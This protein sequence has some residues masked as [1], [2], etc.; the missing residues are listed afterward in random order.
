MT[1]PNTG[2][3]RT[4]LVV[5]A[6]GAAA[7]G[8][9]AC[10]A[11]QTSQTANQVAAVDGGRG[12]AGELTVNNLQ[13]VLDDEGSEGRVGFAVSF[14]GYGVDEAVSIDSVQID[15]LPVQLGETQPMERGCSIIF[16]AHEGAEPGE[17]EG[18]ICVENAVATLPASEDLK[19]GTSVPATLTFSNGDQIETQA[20]I[21]G[22]IVEAGDFTR[23]A[24][25]AAA[26]E[27]N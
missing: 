20:A 3:R 5:L 27:G 24:E 10:S 17:A 19:I 16:D 23:P 1:S 22:S 6:V 11:G 12:S 25:T 18:D 7:L 21:M 14:T 13:V 9:S 15:G 2:L 26:T 4:A 8:A